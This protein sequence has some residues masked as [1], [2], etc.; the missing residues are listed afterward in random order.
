MQTKSVNWKKLNILQVYDLLQHDKDFFDLY[1]TLLSKKKSKYDSNDKIV[2]LHNDTE[3]FYYDAKIGF[4]IHNLLTCWQQA[5]IPWH[6]LLIITNHYNYG[7]I[8]RES[9][10]FHPTDSPTVVFSMINSVSYNDIKK[11]SNKGDIANKKIQKFA[12]FLA[13]GIVRSH[14]TAFVKWLE[15]KTLTDKIVLSYNTSRDKKKQKQSK[16]LDYSK[17]NNISTD[18]SLNTVTANLHRI[19]ENFLSDNY[20]LFE[21]WIDQPLQRMD[22]K[23]LSDDPS[24]FYNCCFLDIVTETVFKYPY[25]FISEKILRPMLLQTPF[26]VFGAA[27][28]LQ[29]LQHNGFQTFDDFW[30]ESY[31]KVQDNGLRFL[32]ICSIIEQLSSLSLDDLN[33]MYNSML[34]ILR[35]NRIHMLQYIENVYKPSINHV[36]I[37]D[38]N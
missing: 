8:I 27:G 32:K 29:C 37:N 13:G 10:R 30:D 24:T 1:R 11:I 14:R 21:S 34:P 23:M 9:R 6:V 31:D 7:Q 17:N 26:I 18:K 15:H 33:T 2:I 22:N 38:Y 5:D 19:N 3:F 25:P 4:S 28:T 35:H 20:D 36:K 12:L 16:H